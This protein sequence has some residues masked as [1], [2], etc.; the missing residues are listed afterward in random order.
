MKNITCK[1]FYWLNVALF[2]ALFYLSTCP[3]SAATFRVTMVQTQT[4]NG[5]TGT[6]K[7]SYVLTAA[8]SG[9]SGSL[10]L[11]IER[12]ELSL[13]PHHG[14]ALNVPKSLI[15]NIEH[16]QWIITRKNGVPTNAVVRMDGKS[17]KVFRDGHLALPSGNIKATS[18]QA[19]SIGVGILRGLVLDMPKRISLGMELFVHNKDALN[20]KIMNFGTQSIPGHYVAV[21][22]LD[23][24]YTFRAARVVVPSSKGSSG[25][26]AVLEGKLK[27]SKYDKTIIPVQ[28]SKV[29]ERYGTGHSMPFKGEFTDYRCFAVEPAEGQKRGQKRMP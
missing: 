2:M 15:K 26:V 6:S 25:D 29:W 14:K 28:N 13:M 24:H 19:I 8:L 1:Y 9:N 3:A 20:S 16:I 23:S 5:E 7:A 27:L 22:K 11:K 10:I 17:F 12:L 18:F 21:Q 4:V